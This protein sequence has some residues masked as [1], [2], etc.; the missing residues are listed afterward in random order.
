MCEKTGHPAGTLFEEGL[1]KFRL[2]LRGG[3]LGQEVR[4]KAEQGDDAQQKLHIVEGD[5]A[6]IE[7][8]IADQIHKP[9]ADGDANPHRKV[10]GK[11]GKR[12]VVAAAWRC[13]PVLRP[14]PWRAPP[15]K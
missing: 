6:E 10:G 1:F 5:N 3:Q 11:R 4:T 12:G 15:T 2:Q 7:L 14:M 8:E 9:G 13:W